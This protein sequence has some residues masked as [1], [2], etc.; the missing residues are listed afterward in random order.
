MCDALMTLHGRSG[1]QLSF[2]TREGKCWTPCK[3]AAEIR[4]GYTVRSRLSSGTLARKQ[5]LPGC[6]H[7]TW[8]M[9]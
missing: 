5:V 3:I 9:L 6:G 8:S 2:A 4:E 1:W 7:K